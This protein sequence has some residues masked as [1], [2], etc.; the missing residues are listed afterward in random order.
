MHTATLEAR[1]ERDQPLTHSLTLTLTHLLTLS[2]TL[3][4]LLTLTYTHTHSLTHT[5][6]LSHT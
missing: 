4:H 1:E 2:H 6:T 5:L 3:T